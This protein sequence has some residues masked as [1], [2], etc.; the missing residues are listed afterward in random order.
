MRMNLRFRFDAAVNIPECR[1]RPIKI[2]L[3][4]V[5][6]AQRQLFAL[7]SFIDLNDL[8]AVCFQIKNLLADGK[9]DLQGALFQRNV[10]TRERT[11]QDRNR[12]GQHTFYAND[13]DECTAHFI[14]IIVL[15]EIVLGVLNKMV[16][17]VKKNENE[18]IQAAMDNS[19]QKQSSELT[20][21]RKKLKEAEKRI[22]E[23]DRLFTRLYEDN[24]SGKISDERFTMMSAG[25]EDEQKKP[26]ATVAELTAYIDSA[27]QEV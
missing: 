9:C 20:K 23:L 16:S 7:S 19:V 18:F 26:K 10:L 5:R 24:V 15:K 14:R 4:P 6:L 3:M 17:F 21:S 12:T 27:E 8:D 2:I 13:K 25:Y 22:A 11:V 1:N